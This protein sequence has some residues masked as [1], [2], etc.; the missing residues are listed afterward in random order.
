MNFISASFYGGLVFLPFFEYLLFRHEEK[1]VHFGDNVVLKNNDAAIC[2]IF[3]N[4]ISCF[5]FM[6]FFFLFHCI[7]DYGDCFNFFGTVVW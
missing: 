4:Q 7:F 2:Y 6:L 3:L 1:L 5:S